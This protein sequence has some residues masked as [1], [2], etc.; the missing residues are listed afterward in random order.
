MRGDY[1][2]SL[3]YCDI[4]LTRHEIWGFVGDFDARV[5]FKVDRCVFLASWEFNSADIYIEPLRA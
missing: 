2:V 4:L 1:S 5:D 3:I